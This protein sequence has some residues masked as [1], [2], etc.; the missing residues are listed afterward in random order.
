MVSMVTVG[1][2]RESVKSH[3]KTFMAGLGNGVQYSGPLP[4]TGTQSHSPGRL[5]NAAHVPRKRKWDWLPSSDITQ[6]PPVA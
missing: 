5:G 3:V 2:G 6:H 4:L 1:K